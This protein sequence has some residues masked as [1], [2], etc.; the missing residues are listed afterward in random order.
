MPLRDKLSAMNI[1]IA[2]ILQWLQLVQDH[3][4]NYLGL[5]IA[6]TLIGW[7]TSMTSDWSKFPLT[8]PGRWQPAVAGFLG[9]LYA[10]LVAGAAAMKAGTPIGAAMLGAI[11]SGVF[12]AALTAFLYD[13]VIRG[14]LN[15][16]VPSWLAWL[17]FKNQPGA[18]DLKTRSSKPP[19][20]N[21]TAAK[22]KV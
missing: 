7:L 13:L 2:T 10:P 5:V 3:K 14:V 1:D 17:S 16:T 8:I 19:P 12:M 11:E 9:L 6:V 18:I 20:S 22:P 15:G 21:T 4:W